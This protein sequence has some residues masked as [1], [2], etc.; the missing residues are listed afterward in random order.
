MARLPR[1]NARRPFLERWARFSFRRRWTVIGAWVAIL[2]ALIA[3][4]GAF[5]GSFVSE[6]RLPGSETQRAADLLEERFPARS[7]DSADLVFEAPGGIESQRSRIQQVIAQVAQIPGVAF[8]E[9]PWEPGGRISE[10]GTVALA[11]VHWKTRSHDVERSDLDQLLHIVDSSQ[12]AGFRVE[13]GG[14]IVIQNEEPAFGSEIYG[15][16]AAVFILLIAFGSVVAMGL[17]LGAA[18]FGLGAGFSVIAL[19]ANVASFPTFSPQFAAMI[20]IGV[21]IDYSLLVVTRFRE[22][23]HSGQ[24]VEEAIVL[25]LTTAGRSVLFA[26]IVVAISFMGLFLMGMP[27]VAALGTAGAIMVL[28]AVLVA[29][30]LMP[31]ALAV[32]GTRVDRWKVPFLHSTEGVE[33]QSWWYRLSMAIQRRP[34]PYFVVTAVLLIGLAT[35]VLK[36]EL[37]FTDAGNSPESMHS[38]RAYDLIAKGFGPGFNGPI[39]AVADLSNG[40]AEALEGIRA[41]LS[42]NGSGN[43]RKGAV[44]TILPT[45]F[46]ES[47]DTAVLTIIPTTSPQDRRSVDLVHELRDDVIPAATEGTGVRVLLTGPGAGQVDAGDRISSRMPLLFVGVIGLSFLLLLVVFRSV[48]V[49]VKAAI[50]NLLSIGASYGVVV[51]I[52]QWGWFSG[53]VGVE[54]GPVEIFL[55]MMMFAILF[56]LSMDYEVFLISRIREEY[57]RT[58]KNSTAVSHG[59]AATARVIT[60]AAAIMV[61][62]FLSFVLGPDRIIKEFGIGLATAIFVDATIVRL[63]LVPSTMALLGD[64]NWWLPGWLDRI[65]PHVN[66]EGLVEPQPVGAPAGGK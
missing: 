33:P 36:M 7:G 16:I 12:A 53:L 41:A 28:F 65:L 48:L 51:A 20:G 50:M 45:V 44:Q 5:A 38:R 19:G 34:L 27:F 29:L 47:G 63:I 18:I 42:D 11:D 3:S 66:V 8:I 59:L 54:K 62:V 31:A 35:P 30:T 55:P 52:F 26:G 32:V 23:I 58:G 25:A 39:I 6:F 22:G 64:A 4:Q 57:L 37:G 24:T 61:T 40:G 10:D 17:P 60:A 1:A 43:G 46:N 14:E 49:A 15:L 56:G 9:S 13:A 2:V 21:G